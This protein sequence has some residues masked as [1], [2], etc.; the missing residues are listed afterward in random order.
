MEKEYAEL[1]DLKVD[2]FTLDNKK[3]TECQSSVL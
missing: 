2:Y 1:S 3:V